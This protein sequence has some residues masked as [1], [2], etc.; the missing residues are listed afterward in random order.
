LGKTNTG[1]TLRAL[2]ARFMLDAPQAGNRPAHNI[3]PQE[4]TMHIL[5]VDDHADFQVLLAMILEDAGYTVVSA[6]NGREALRYLHLTTELPSVILLDIAMPLM[7]GSEF[8][9]EQQ[10]DPNLAAIP[11]VV[12]T[13]RRDI[14][15]EIADTAAVYLNKPIDL[16]TLLATVQ[17][18]TA[19]NV[20]SVP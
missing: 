11:V 4:I 15:D 12:I 20:T 19:L 6:A 13:A 2:V 9:G 16:D 3:A 5:V 14:P 8:L 17:Q 1:S 18:Y 10:R 7:T